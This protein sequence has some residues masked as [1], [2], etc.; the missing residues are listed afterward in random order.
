MFLLVP[1]PPKK[2][3]NA[4]TRSL[5]FTSLISAQVTLLGALLGEWQVGPV[6]GASTASSA[7]HTRRN[8]LR[9]RAPAHV[10]TL[11]VAGDLG[12]PGRRSRHRRSHCSSARLGLGQNSLCCI[13]ES[14]CSGEKNGSLQRSWGPLHH[15]QLAMELTGTQNLTL[16]LW[17]AICRFWGQRK[18]TPMLKMYFVY[19][20][21]CV[22]HLFAYICCNLL[23]HHLKTFGFILCKKNHTSYKNPGFEWFWCIGSRY[24]ALANTG[25][26]NYGRRIWIMCIHLR[27]SSRSHISRILW[28]VYWYV[29]NNQ[30]TIP[31]LAYN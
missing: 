11:T 25:L 18:L 7:L 2:T 6:H 29:I 26:S 10:V 17:C 15:I 22:C 16:R 24:G 13:Q 1:S 9:R 30:L 27:Q 28:L 23:W 21:L 4:F 20:C 31:Q 8:A 19:L 12:G 5:S 14:K 3:T